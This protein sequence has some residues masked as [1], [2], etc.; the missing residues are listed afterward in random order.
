[1]THAIRIDPATGRKLFNTRAAKASEN[2]AGKGYSLVADDALK[3]LPRSARGRRFNAEEQAK[4]RAFKEA[5][6]GAA[7]YM[8]MEGEFAKYLEDVYSAPADRARGADRRLRD[9]GHRRRLRRAAAVVQAAR[10]RLHRRALLREGRRRRRHLVLEPLSR[11][12][13]RR[14]VLQLP[15]AAGGD[16]LLPDD[17]VRLR[18]RDPRILP[19][20]GRERFGFYDRCLFHTTVERTDWDEAAARW[21]VETD[22]GDAHARALRRARQ[23]HPDHAEARPHRGHG[24]ASRARRSTPRAGTTT[25]TSQASASA[26]S[27]PAPRPCRWCR[28]S[29]R[30]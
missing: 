15:A 13:L 29:P 21:I 9:P 3:T 20:D 2:I 26:S 14:R 6:R 1:M 23:R 18:L 27:A 19:D 7:D 25:S 11:H 22:R 28:R 16:G 8:A 12:R 30:S 4:Y 10:R 24:D 5:R 17:E